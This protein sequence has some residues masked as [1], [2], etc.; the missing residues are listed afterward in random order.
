[1]SAL[2]LNLVD[3]LA[4]VDDDSSHSTTTTTDL[5]AVCQVVS[6]HLPNLVH[7]PSLPNDGHSCTHN[8]VAKLYIINNTSQELWTLGVSTLPST[9][10]SSGTSSSFSTLPNVHKYV[11]L[12]RPLEESSNMSTVAMSGETL[13]RANHRDGI[14][15]GVHYYVPVK[16]PRTR[17]VVGV[18][19]VTWGNND[20]SSELH[21][22]PSHVSLA[23]AEQRRVLMTAC[24]YIGR[25]VH[26]MTSQFETKTTLAA[27]GARLAQLQNRLEGAENA[28]SSLRGHLQ[29]ERSL[30]RCMSAIAT[31]PRKEI[32]EADDDVEWNELFRIAE[33]LVTELVG[34]QSKKNDQQNRH[35]AKL[36][37]LNSKT[38]EYWRLEPNT[39]LSASTIIPTGIEHI[40]ASSTHL[41]TTIATGRASFGP[42]LAMLSARGGG[43]LTLPTDDDHASVSK[44]DLFVLVPVIDGNRRI[45]GVLELDGPTL[46]PSKSIKK[47]ISVLSDYGAHIALAMGRL[48]RRSEARRTHR[49]SMTRLRS[50]RRRSTLLLAIEQLWG[51]CTSMP[52]VFLAFDTEI[53]RLLAGSN[54]WNNTNSGSAT[55]RASTISIPPPP[56]STTPSSSSSLL[57]SSLPL[58]P[59]PSL[60]IPQVGSTSS[61]VPLLSLRDLRVGLYMTERGGRSLWT[62]SRNENRNGNQDKFVVPVGKG[63]LVGSAASYG[64]SRVSA[65]GR[66]VA[67]VVRKFSGEIAA[68]L[69]LDLS[70]NN[71]HDEILSP[72]AGYDIGAR[73]L[74]DDV[75]Q[76]ID[77]LLTK[78]DM[79]L[80]KIW[81]RHVAVAVDHFEALNGCV[82]GMGN[83]SEALALLEDK[84][85][86]LNDNVDRHTHSALRFCRDI[87]SAYGQYSSF[88]RRGSYDWMYSC[89]RR[90]MRMV[91]CH[92]VMIMTYDE[93]R[94]M[95][96]G[97]TTRTA[98]VQAEDEEEEHKTP[99]STTHTSSN[100]SSSSSSKK[101]RRDRTTTL[102]ELPLGTRPSTFEQ[103]CFQQR[104]VLCETVRHWPTWMDSDDMNGLMSSINSGECELHLMAAPLV[105]VPPR[106]Q[107]N[108]SGGT[109]G[110]IRSG[111]RRRRKR[112]N[113]TPS[114]AAHGIDRADHRSIQSNDNN[115]EDD[116]IGVIIFARAVPSNPFVN[117]EKQTARLIGH[118]LG[119]MVYSGNEN[120]TTNQAQSSSHRTAAPAQSSSTTRVNVAEVRSSV[121][122]RAFHQ[123]L[124]TS[125]QQGGRTTRDRMATFLN[126]VGQLNGLMWSE[127]VLTNLVSQQ[128]TE[129]VVSR[130]V[131]TF[132]LVSRGDEQDERDEE[133]RIT[134]STP[135]AMKLI[136]LSTTRT[137][138]LDVDSPAARAVLYGQP[139]LSKVH[140]P[141]N[142]LLVFLPCNVEK[143]LSLVSSTSNISTTPTKRIDVVG[144]IEIVITDVTQEPDS[145]E[146]G[147]LT[148]WASVV[149]AALMR[150]SR[151]S[152]WREEKEMLETRLTMMDNDRMTSMVMDISSRKREGCYRLFW[153][154]WMR[155]IL[156]ALSKSWLKWRR[157][158]YIMTSKL[159]SSLSEH[160]MEPVN[161]FKVIASGS[162]SP[163]GSGF[164]EGITTTDT[165]DVK[166][167]P[168]HSMFRDLHACTTLSEIVHITSSSVARAFQRVHVATL[169]PLAIDD[170][171]VDTSQLE[172]VDSEMSLHARRQALRRCAFDG[173]RIT[174]RHGTR[175]W[176]YEPIYV[177]RDGKKGNVNKLIGVLELGFLKSA[178]QRTSPWLE[179]REN[180]VLEVGTR[181][182]GRVLDRVWSSMELH[183]LMSETRADITRMKKSQLK[184]AE[185]KVCEKRTITSAKIQLRI[186]TE[187]LTVRHLTSLNDILCD[188]PSLGKSNSDQNSHTSTAKRTNLSNMLGAESIGV[189]FYNPATEMLSSRSTSAS[190]SL[191]GSSDMSRAVREN[192]IVTTEDGRCTFIPI[193][194]VSNNHS[195]KQW[196]S[197]Q[198]L[199]IVIDICW[200]RSDVDSEENVIQLPVDGRPGMLLFLRTAV[201]LVATRCTKDTS[202]SVEKGS[203]DAKGDKS[204]VNAAKTMSLLS[205]TT[206]IAAI[207]QILECTSVKDTMRHFSTNI[208][209]AVGAFSVELYSMVNNNM[210][211]TSTG[212]HDIARRIM[213]VDATHGDEWTPPKVWTLLHRNDVKYGEVYSDD[214][215]FDTIKH[216]KIQIISGDENEN[217]E[218]AGGGTNTTSNRAAREITTA[219]FPIDHESEA[220]VIGVLKIQWINNMEQLK[221]NTL[222]DVLKRCVP[223]I[224]LK[225]KE[226][227]PLAAGIGRGALDTKMNTNSRETTQQWVRRHSH[228]DTRVSSGAIAVLRWSILTKRLIVA[229]KRSAMHLVL[230][231]WLRSTLILAKTPLATPSGELSVCVGG[232]NSFEVDDDRI[233][234][235]E[236]ENMELISIID[237]HSEWLRHVLTYRRSM[238]LHTCKSTIDIIARSKY[239]LQA[240]VGHNA[241]VHVFMLSDSTNHDTHR[242]SKK[243]RTK[244]IAR[245]PSDVLW[246]ID[247]VSG[248]IFTVTKT[249]KGFKNVL[250]TP[251]EIHVTEGKK[252]STL[253]VP[254]YHAA[255]HPSSPIR[256]M[257]VVRVKV[258]SSLLDAVDKEGLLVLLDHVAA[259]TTMLPNIN[260][261]KNDKASGINAQTMEIME[262]ELELVLTEREGYRNRVRAL[263]IAL[264]E[265]TIECDRMTWEKIEMQDEEEKIVVIATSKKHDVA[266]K[267][268]MRPTTSPTEDGAVNLGVVQMSPSK[269]HGA[270]SKLHMSSTSSPTRNWGKVRTAIDT[271]TALRGASSKQNMSPRNSRTR[272]TT[273]EEKNVLEHKQSAVERAPLSGEAVVERALA[274]QD[275][276]RAFRE[277]QGGM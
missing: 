202:F 201:E 116:A 184:E 172:V 170:E 145:A 245:V 141:T 146:L 88:I 84:N 125:G 43:S 118:V 223:L 190:Y 96:V 175:P 87:F 123:L 249:R 211:T 20:R 265:T 109:G 161:P 10:T 171:D 181:V 68:V 45:V 38:E 82:L 147:I 236:L 262:K 2:L 162:A 276:S 243:K 246:S 54:K 142:Q 277:E 106:R 196:S 174:T 221:L 250:N 258:I 114:S 129:M 63:T 71:D 178:R 255:D 92:A 46:L 193:N 76:D 198:M 23:L 239:M 182:I 99:S 152:A 206:L 188:N 30:V 120:T 269:L 60:P 131:E 186:A 110:S 70:H 14:I 231:E 35:F 166:A 1:M 136:S 18:L 55:Q 179:R 271:T 210:T 4:S 155:N 259:I 199:P 189:F 204:L 104:A 268:N 93:R 164:G 13:T 103:V 52:S 257:G 253:Y 176:M 254:L 138:S 117:S 149:G 220:G 66:S 241:V 238:A 156:R 91:D 74:R 183:S 61:S 275:M 225:M 98:A 177:V 260:K 133:N 49:E 44:T 273:R 261:E 235:Y 213:E 130:S 79:S 244:R 143:D 100:S 237:K 107:Q 144:V 234:E 40:D 21:T 29:V 256:I 187:L 6:V 226:E 83:A 115:E 200:N 195:H 185:T 48:E 102:Y 222:I 264:T 3:A 228:T 85:A 77:P 11:Q 137:I 37:V 160:L 274:V 47:S 86:R 224:H 169:Q 192:K 108:T 16:A 80:L 33:D 229:S 126:F 218:D 101:G 252:E 41:T 36:Y 67:L 73:S 232:E 119:P 148:G 9:L 22:M 97:A 267:Q 230:K 127:A 150:C 219:Y 157:Y 15:L 58:S 50:S 105:W 251:T 27:T 158:T 203:A 153:T 135:S 121:Q 207:L 168:L 159:S 62:L 132:K 75:D 248:E 65:D 140:E 263:E 134:G 32:H 216:K 197:K 17:R 128:G 28:H 215:M 111:S 270:A 51:K 214:P 56:S 217:I 39:M 205:S 25:K 64:E 247:D 227:R 59:L 240:W 5:G 208:K 266:S 78:E 154:L 124:R 31:W 191:H 81:T 165:T 212:M 69:I 95:L 90:A 242:T 209:N 194:I 180:M 57:S 34:A 112:R 173:I 139:V 8:A 24:D 151:H 89:Q 26:E 272:T 233:L 19:H 163:S 12:K 7:T 42:S 113:R 94:D 122:S 167:P 72:F 53:R